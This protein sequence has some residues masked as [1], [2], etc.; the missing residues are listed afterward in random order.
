MERTVRNTPRSGSVKTGTAS[1]ANGIP[2]CQRR[3]TRFPHRGD[4]LTLSTLQV[5]SLHID[6]FR[7]ICEQKLEGGVNLCEAVRTLDFRIDCFW[8]RELWKGSYVM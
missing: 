4:D 8:V 3:A 7:G 6:L 5:S 1:S 2:I